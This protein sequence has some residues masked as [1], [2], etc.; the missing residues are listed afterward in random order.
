[1]APTPFYSPW[2]RAGD[3]VI[4]SGQL[5]LLPETGDLVEGGTAAELRQALVNG[6][7][8]LRGAGA[9]L[10]NVVKATI[11]IL[12]MGDFTACNEVW[13]ETF[14]DPL[15]ARS[16]VAVA[17]LPRGARAEVEFFAYSPEG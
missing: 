9:D 6:S 11:F 7:A 1:M 10:S 16:T 12:D 4:V 3:L 14:S 5:G 17:A 15:P 13:L 8:V 2:R